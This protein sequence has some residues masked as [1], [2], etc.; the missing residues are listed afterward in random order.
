MH[1]E[2]DLATALADVARRCGARGFTFDDLARPARRRQATIGDV[3]DWLARARSAGYLEDVGFD[4]G[5]GGLGTG[6]RRYR[7]AA[8]LGSA[9]EQR[10]VCDAA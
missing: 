2:T 7:L 10:P 8:E 9:A 4:R 1:D 5:M 3:A 6:A